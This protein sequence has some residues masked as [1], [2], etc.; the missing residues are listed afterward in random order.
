[1]I[2]K[3]GI[4]LAAMLL[5]LTITGPLMAQRR[6]GNDAQKPNGPDVYAPKPASAEE[7]KAFTA[8]QNEAN[9]TNKV[10][11]ADTFLTTYPNSQLS[12]YVQRFRM[13]SLGK[14]GKYKEAAAAGEA[15]LT[16][17]TKYF[18]GLIAKADEQKNAPKDK[19]SKNDKDKNE[20]IIDKNSDGFKA[21]ADNTE[22][23]MMYYYQNLMSDYQALNDAPK[24]IEWAKKALGE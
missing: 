23:A 2:N 8:L 17:E 13:E 19:K 6:N 10:A 9:P 22:K 20:V 1:M 11:L 24:T 4:A 7:A 12:G 21:F 14:M 3:N 16:L 5:T 18:E 15:G